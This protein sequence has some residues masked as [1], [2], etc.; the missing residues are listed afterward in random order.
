M[1]FRFFD[2]LITHAGG[3]RET[4]FQLRDAVAL[5]AAAGKSVKSFREKIVIFAKDEPVV[6][7]GRFYVGVR[8]FLAAIEIAGVERDAVLLGTARRI[9][10]DT[11]VLGIGV[12][13]RH[14]AVGADRAR[15]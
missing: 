5:K 1:Y 2:P 6:G 8:V 9:D 11:D 4:Q 7:G 13:A 12:A 14:Q 10:G 15:P 3:G